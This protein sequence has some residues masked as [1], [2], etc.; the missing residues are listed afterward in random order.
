MVSALFFGA[1]IV[2][3]IIEALLGSYLMNYTKKLFPPIVTGSVV[4]VIG[5]SLMGVAIDYSAGISGLPGY[6]SWQNYALAF[7]TLTVIL[8]VNRLS[9]GFVKGISVLIGTVV[10]FAVSVAMGMVDFTAVNNAAWFAI[11]TP[12][13]YGIEF[14][15]API[16]IV[17][18]IY[19]VSMIEYVGDTTGVAM[20]AVNRE[21]TQ[22]ELSAGV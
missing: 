10:A 11:P 2:G 5:L 1:V 8:L 13:K 22:K 12:F 15:L 17:T 4:M 6:G 19:M 7:F 18:L 21:P 14:K 9:K 16:L 3:G 20:I